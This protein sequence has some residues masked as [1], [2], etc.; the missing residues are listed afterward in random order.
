MVVQ[1]NN[2]KYQIGDK[3][4]SGSPA[5]SP[6]FDP[7]FG[8]IDK[9]SENEY[10]IFGEDCA[11][12]IFAAKDDKHIYVMID[13]FQ[14]IFDV[15]PDEVLFADSN[16]VNDDKHDFITSPMPGS[17]VS[18]LVNEG[19]EIESGMPVMIIEAMKMESKLYASISG[20][21]SKI[22]CKPGQQI[23][24]DNVLMEITKD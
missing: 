3:F 14:Y 6:G 9:M 24:S 10:R 1:Y 7:H 23:D 18:V 8:F 19:D 22:F 5:K 15:K 20:K 16:S 21:V 11:W 2:Q 12:K 4:I 13:S 17:V